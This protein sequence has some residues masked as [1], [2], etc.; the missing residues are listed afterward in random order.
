MLHRTITLLAEHWSLQ[1][2]VFFMWVK[3]PWTSP[4][5]GTLIIT[6]PVNPETKNKKRDHRHKHQITDKIKVMKM[7]IAVQF[8][9][10]PGNPSST[11]WVACNNYHNHLSWQSVLI[12]WRFERNILSKEL[13]IHFSRMWI[14]RKLLTSWKR[15]V[16]SIKN[17]VC[18]K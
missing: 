1:R 6:V 8:W 18:W 7:L 17:E 3:K 9:D 10:D 16:Y 15:L 11:V 4:H 5:V 2:L 13:C 14:Q 12:R